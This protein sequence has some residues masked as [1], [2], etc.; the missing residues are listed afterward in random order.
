M[1]ET[2]TGLYLLFCCKRGSHL[3]ASE[4]KLWSHKVIQVC[5]RISLKKTL[6]LFT[7]PWL[8][9]L[10]ML[11]SS[12]S[13]VSLVVPVSLMQDNKKYLTFGNTDMTRQ[14]C[15]LLRLHETLM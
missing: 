10:N 13:F 8:T 6:K 11:Y 1:S 9:W 3:P 2:A 4:A 5:L 15:R 14:E 12:I 7:F